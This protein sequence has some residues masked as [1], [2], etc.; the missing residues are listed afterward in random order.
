MVVLGGAEAAVAGALPM[1]EATRD[2]FADSP[3]L[4]DGRWLLL[5]IASDADEGDL[6]RLLTVKLPPRIRARLASKHHPVPA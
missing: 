2:A 3:Q 4:R 5:P 1:G 6:L